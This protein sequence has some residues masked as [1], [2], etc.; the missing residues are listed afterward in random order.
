PPSHPPS[1]H[2]A[3]PIFAIDT[4]VALPDLRFVLDHGAKP[5][6]A[7]GR[8]EPWSALI[9]D[10]GRLDNVS[11]KLSGLVTEAHWT[12]WAPDDLRPYADRKSTRLNSSHQII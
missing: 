6:I 9:R 10:L 8:R 12:S 5:A 1:L 3:L 11:C 7:S 2:D 4:A